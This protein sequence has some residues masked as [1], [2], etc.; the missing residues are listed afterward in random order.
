MVTQRRGV[1]SS[2]AVARAFH[3]QYT[4]YRMRIL[5]WTEESVKRAVQG[6]PRSDAGTSSREVGS[7]DRPTRCPSACQETG[8]HSCITLR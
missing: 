1:S 7:V 8:P 4:R 5:L 3:N 2:R 6:H